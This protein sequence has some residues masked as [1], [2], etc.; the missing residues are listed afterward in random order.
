[1]L[2]RAALAAPFLLFV[3]CAQPIEPESVGDYRMRDVGTAETNNNN[4]STPEE[5]TGAPA[6]DEDTGTAPASDSAA[7][8]SMDSGT[9][10]TVTP[11]TATPD[12]APVD[13]GTPDTGPADTGPPPPVDSGTGTVI[14]FPVFADTYV[15][16][17]D[18]NFWNVGD[19]IQGSRATSL[20][21]ITSI[22]GTVGITNSL[23][24]CGALDLIVSV[25]GT[26]VGTVKITNTHGAAVPLSLTFPA[27]TGPTYVIRY[28]AGNT[29][30]SG[31][32]SLSF[33]EDSTKLTLK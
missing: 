13:T 1:M 31:C 14:T 32:G 5:D 25:N 8:P 19:Y 15:I 17:Y 21:S 33:V 7:P 18:P 4:N 3:G 28:Q 23:S 26:T 12:T 22:S 6:V 2:R 24:T 11:D 29:V 30:K 27:A 20:A 9:P 10:D 16:K